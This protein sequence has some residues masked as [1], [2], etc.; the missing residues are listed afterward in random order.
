MTCWM[1]QPSLAKIFVSS[2]SMSPPD[3]TKSAVFSVVG[4]TA[5]LQG[6]VM[7]SRLYD[8]HHCTP[9]CNPWISEQPIPLVQSPALLRV[10]RGW[11]SFAP[12]A[13]GGSCFYATAPQHRV[14]T[15]LS[16]QRPSLRTPP[17]FCVYL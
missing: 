3:A 8:R 5:L 14:T 7:R 10:L 11:T 13:K 17:R 2:S 4:A 6:V 1:L 16:P 12:F 15:R 9:P